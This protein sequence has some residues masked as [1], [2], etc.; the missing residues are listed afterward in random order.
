MLFRSTGS[1]DVSATPSRSYAVAS[2]L[3]YDN[4]NGT[5]FIS[6]PDLGGQGN[7]VNVSEGQGM[8]ASLA[9]SEQQL[10]NSFYKK[11]ILNL[12]V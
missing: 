11:N 2:R 4:L 5:T 8:V 9:P 3:P 1:G 7:S 10:L 12:V 6:L